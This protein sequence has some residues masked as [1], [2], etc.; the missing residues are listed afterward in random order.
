MLYTLKDVFFYV[1][2]KMPRFESPLGG[3]S[4]DT[5]P[6]REFDVPDESGPPPVSN[7][8]RRQQQM[9][10]AANMNLAAIQEFQSRMGGSHNGPPSPPQYQ[11]PI[12]PTLNETD[13]VGAAEREFR[14]MREQQRSGKVRLNEGAKRRVEM[15]LGMTRSVRTVEIE[16]RVY[17]FTTL[18]SKDMRDA[19]LEASKFD[20]T[21]E[22]PF[23]IRK[24][25]LS[26][27]LTKV[28]GVET[29]QFIAARDLESKMAL[30]DELDEPLL[31]R[32][33]TEYL[34]LVAEAREK[35]SIKS[36][37]DAKEVLEDLKK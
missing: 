9:E 33:Y 24:Q 35:Y 36:E 19:I 30:I 11:A 12:H 10:A 7:A 17:E 14:E 15:L 29:E 16:G 18:K 26:R 3:K 20:G 8:S 4:F 31:G 5:Q 22:G 28:A 25:L 27:S 23:E 32:L 13:S 37:A 34:L 6:M 1:E 21:V 2:L